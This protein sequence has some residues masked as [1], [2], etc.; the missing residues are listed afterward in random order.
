[1]DAIIPRNVTLAEAPSHGKP[2][3]LYQIA[4]RGAQLYMQL[5]KEVLKRTA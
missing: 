2:V 4:S 5:A 3:L 1:F